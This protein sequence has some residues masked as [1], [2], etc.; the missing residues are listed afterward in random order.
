MEKSGFFNSSGGD[1]VYNATDF[2]AYFS[3]FVSNGIFA[4]NPNS[5][6]VSP[7]AGMTLQVSPG[8]AFIGGYYYE[9]TT[10]LELELEIANGVN[11]RIDRVVI[12][13]SASNRDIKLA[14]LT[15]AASSVPSAQTLAR[16]SDIYELALADIAVGKGVVAIRANDITD[17]RYNSALCG[18]VNS[19]LNA[20]YE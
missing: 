9:N 11:P 18:T 2:A 1:R 17:T 3:R 20:V 13:F 14:V 4:R 7:R 12:R 10:E 8:S 19:L 15:G 16:T 6:N 5:L